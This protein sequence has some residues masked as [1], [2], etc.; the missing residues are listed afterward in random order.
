MRGYVFQ[1]VS[2]MPI[3]HM[4]VVERK[5]GYEKER[6]MSNICISYRRE[7]NAG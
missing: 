4:W 5:P 1:L 7:D 2:L 6:A 3:M